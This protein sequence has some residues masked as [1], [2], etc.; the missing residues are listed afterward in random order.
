MQPDNLVTIPSTAS[1]TQT[2]THTRSSAPLPHELKIRELS[3]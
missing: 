3:G 1:V 2:P